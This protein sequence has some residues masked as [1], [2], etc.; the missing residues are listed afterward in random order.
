MIN[1]TKRILIFALARTAST[2]LMNI[3]NVHK[4]IYAISEPFNIK[5]KDHIKGLGVKGICENE[6][7]STSELDESLG[8]VFLEFNLV[9]HIWHPS[10][11][12]FKDQDHSYAFSDIVPINEYLLG[13]FDYVM[14]VKR[15]NILKRV[16]S[17]LMSQ[18]SG[19]WDSYWIESIAKRKNYSYEPLKM[20]T[21]EWY[22]KF[23]QFYLNYF[24]QALVKK[25]I[26]YMEITMEDLFE[27]NLTVE[28]RIEKYFEMSEFI[29]LPKKY[30]Y[31]QMNLIGEYL[32]SPRH[33]QNSMGSYKGVPNAMEI[34]EAFGSDETGWLFK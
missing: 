22:I 21:I 34:E 10:G 30:N 3:F 15:R 18:Q 25:N 1:Y 32:T 8:R 2:T 11:F 17:L 19:L 20:S 31:D 23:E 14:F 5:N 28:E 16:V 7:S 33:I 6:I 26:K 9:K 27:S 29:E 12:P 13:K 4:S 24:K